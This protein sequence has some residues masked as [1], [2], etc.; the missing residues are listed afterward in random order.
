MQNNL[1]KMNMNLQQI[2][3]M[4]VFQSSIALSLR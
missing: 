3:T 4:T 2:L 1:E